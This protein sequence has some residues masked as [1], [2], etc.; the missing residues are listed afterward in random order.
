MITESGPQVKVMQ[1]YSSDKKSDDLATPPAAAAPEASCQATSP[2]CSDEK[3]RGGGSFNK[4]DRDSVQ[5]LEKR[6]SKLR[7]LSRKVQQN[8]A[9]K[10]SNLN[11]ALL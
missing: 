8:Y 2:F 3:Q 6:I 11:T 7:N 4:R 1:G 9:M 10:T 5:D